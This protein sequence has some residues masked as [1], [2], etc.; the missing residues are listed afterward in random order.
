MVT[1]RNGNLLQRSARM[2]FKR[3]H[4]TL[5]HASK[6]VLILEILSI[7]HLLMIVLFSAPSKKRE[8]I[9]VAL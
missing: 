3:R 2:S 5:L 9:L 7:K 4:Q 8:I 6:P 1:C